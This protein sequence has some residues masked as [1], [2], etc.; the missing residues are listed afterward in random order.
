MRFVI[1]L[2]A[3]LI[4]ACSGGEDLA[5]AE[6]AIDRFHQEL[7]AGQIDRIQSEASSDWKNAAPTKESLQFLSAVRSKL[8][9]FHSG[10]QA[11]W[12][13]NYGTNGTMVVVQYN[14][15]FAKGEAVETFTF[16]NS[17]KGSEL[18]GYNVNS[19]VFVTG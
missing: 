5:R 18:V 15:R 9:A 12:T 7:N 10:K 4:A 13:V 8:G 1:G 14:S 17:D 2:F 3:L 16:R 6:K 11:G 19:K